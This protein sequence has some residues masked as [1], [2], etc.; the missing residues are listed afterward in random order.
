MNT[1]FLQL[2]ELKVTDFHQIELS[3]ESAK[4]RY[5]AAAEIE[6]QAWEMFYEGIDAGYTND[7]TGDLLQHAE[8]AE[9]VRLIAYQDWN[10]AKLALL[11]VYQ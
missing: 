4:V 1:T 2:P 11:A 3:L 5:G 9:T 8:L 10:D 6:R 7:V